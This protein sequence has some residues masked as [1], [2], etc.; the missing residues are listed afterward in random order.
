[1][2][3]RFVNAVAFHGFDDESGVLIGGT[4]PDELKERLR[5]A[6]DDALPTTFAVRVAT[7]DERYGGDDPRNIVNRLS[8]CGGIQ[9]EQGATPREDHGRDIA[10]AVADV[11]RPRRPRDRD[12]VGDALAQAWDWARG[13]AERL[14]RRR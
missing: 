8:P 1:M 13:T 12:G 9:I 4:A 3:R 6:I 5:Q 11:F 14:R 7:P 10:N 2:K